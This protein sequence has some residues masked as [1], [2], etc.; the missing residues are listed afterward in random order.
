LTNTIGRIVA[1]KM[2]SQRTESGLLLRG[3]RADG[4]GVEV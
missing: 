3:G 1:Q 2:N 4:E